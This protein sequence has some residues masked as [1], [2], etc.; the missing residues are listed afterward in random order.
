MKSDK[1]LERVLFISGGVL[2]VVAVFLFIK[3]ERK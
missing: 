2:A 1:T 3:G